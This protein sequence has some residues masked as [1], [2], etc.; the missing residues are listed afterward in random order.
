MR[1]WLGIV[2]GVLLFSSVA[3]A[4][5][6]EG[7]RLHFNYG[8]A[9]FGVKHYKTAAA[10]FLA[11][12]E[13]VKDPVLWYNIGE[14][15]ERAGNG[16]GAVEAYRAYLK[17]VPTAQDR[18]A[19]D[20]RI[21]RIV[22]RRYKLPSQSSPGDNPAAVAR[23]TPPPPVAP[24]PVA[25]TPAAPTT[26][27][28]VA[29]APVVTAPPPVAP[30]PSPPPV[31]L[32]PAPAPVVTTSPAPLA[33]APTLVDR[34]PPRSRKLWTGA[35][36]SF[37]ITLA[38]LGA[39]VGLSVAANARGNDLAERASFVRP[40]GQPNAFDPVQQSAYTQIADEGRLYER[41]AIGCYAAAGVA[42]VATTVL[43]IVDGRRNKASHAMVAPTVGKGTAGLV[44][45]GSF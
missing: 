15:R 2:L 37:G 35:W 4:Q 31:H 1:E 10:E 28:P 19:V 18:V 34:Q 30:S 8:N 43:F 38:A 33:P 24:P 21:K 29:P 23:V 6:F 7:A 32:E 5:D 13:I 44:L 25:P 42:A 36:V 26:P 27:R 22:A 45:A 3:H 16:K 9:A 40:D 41:V 39:G 11:A 20:L 17:G 14:S 12:Y